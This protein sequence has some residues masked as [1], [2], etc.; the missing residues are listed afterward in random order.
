MTHL[1]TPTGGLYD[2]GHLAEVVGMTRAALRVA[3]TRH[4]DRYPAP[5]GELNGGPVWDAA[6]VASWAAT[7]Q[8]PRPGRPRQGA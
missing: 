5:I 3:R 8:P 7:Y 2:Q 4:P 6:Q 1:P